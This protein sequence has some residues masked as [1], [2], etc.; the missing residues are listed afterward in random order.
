MTHDADEDDQEHDEDDLP[1][2]DLDQKSRNSELETWYY[3]LTS[4][5]H[6]HHQQPH[7]SHYSHHHHPA[8]SPDPQP[9]SPDGL[10]DYIS[11]ED[12]SDDAG[13]PL[14][15]YMDVLNLIVNGM[16]SEMDPDDLNTNLDL[17]IDNSD[18]S[19]HGDEDGDY[20]SGQ[21]PYQPS[22][23]NDD[24]THL[25]VPTPVGPPNSLPHPQPLLP[26]PTAAQTLAL[27]EG[28]GP[29]GTTAG[30]E[31]FETAHPPV[32]SNPNP[33]MLGPGNYGLTDF[34]HRWARQSRPMQAIARDQGRFP[35]PNRI[36]ELAA[37]EVTRID[38]DELEGDFCDMQGIDWD[39]IGVTRR[40]A[41]KQRLET[42]N[43]YVN[44]EGSD[45]WS[46]SS[47]NP[48]IDAASNANHSTERLA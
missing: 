25:H 39:D 12:D 48:S 19:D 44:N 13:A 6:H 4:H 34:L 24:M 7:H 32:F 31:W 46:V 40:E 35:W 27:L 38:Y 11:D 42:Y 45:V 36:N 10:D 47:F 22:H 28:P 43:N 33:N 29:A 14:L 1:A 3:N 21:A 8:H 9:V 15:T 20:H 30:S 17:D 23:T 5:H 37:K 2:Q 26:V 41:R 16:D 18:L